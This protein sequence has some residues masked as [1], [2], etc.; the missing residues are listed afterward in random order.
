MLHLAWYTSTGAS[1]GVAAS[2]SWFN[3]DDD[4]DAPGPQGRPART[5]RAGADAAAPDT[6]TTC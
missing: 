6:G 2:W 5:P 4:E 1:A 3:A